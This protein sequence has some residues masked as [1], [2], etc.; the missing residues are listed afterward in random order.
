M[1]DVWG[2]EDE[3]TPELNKAE[4]VELNTRFEIRE[5]FITFDFRILPTELSLFRY[6]N[7][8]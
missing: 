6:C 3:W 7:D 8:D 2:F 1:T 5:E 4:W